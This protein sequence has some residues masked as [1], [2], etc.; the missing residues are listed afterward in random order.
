M[1]SHFKLDVHAVFG[2]FFD[3]ITPEMPG[4]EVTVEVKVLLKLCKLLVHVR[5]LQK[6]SQIPVWMHPPCACDNCCCT[7][8]TLPCLPAAAATH[9]PSLGHMRVN[10]L[11]CAVQSIRVQTS[12]GQTELGI[13]YIAD[14]CA[15][16]PELRMT[17]MNQHDPIHSYMFDQAGMLLHGNA[18]ALHALNGNRDDQSAG[19]CTA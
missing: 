11:L 5:S 8:H 15:S 6:V 1:V 10:N 12:T 14:M 9:Q 4:L 16:A 7:I 18:A 2:P 17:A 19:K 13:M 3:G